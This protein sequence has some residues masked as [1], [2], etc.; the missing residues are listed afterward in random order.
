MA[1][2]NVYFSVDALAKWVPQI[3]I[4][5]SI[6]AGFSIT[7]FLLIFSR[8]PFKLPLLLPRYFAAFGAGLIVW[9]ILLWWR[10]ALPFFGLE[11]V[12]EFIAGG[13][14]FLTA[15]FCNYYIGNISAGFRIEMLIN[16]AEMN[17]EV[18]LDEWMAQYG[19]S[20]GMHY[21][22]ENRLKSTL[23]PWRLVVWKD[24]QI[25]LTRFGHFIGQIN[26][27]LASLFSEK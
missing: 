24:N 3:A 17:R 21:F 19:K 23:L 13:L 11:T 15:V 1:I 14:I 12:L 10:R 18:T 20:R 2:S 16:L 6:L 4:W 22:L 27:F 9:I 7:I 8:S 25:T 5:T 26:C